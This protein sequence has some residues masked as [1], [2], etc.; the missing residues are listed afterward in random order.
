MAFRQEIEAIVLRV[1]PA[2]QSKNG[3][4]VREIDVMIPA[5][6]ENQRTQWYQLTEVAEEFSFYQFVKHEKYRFTVFVNG[7][8]KK[9][10]HINKLNIQR[11]AKVKS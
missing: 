5:M 4:M 3:K 9:D 7:L 1:H 6:R 2:E 8:N 10:R 11:V